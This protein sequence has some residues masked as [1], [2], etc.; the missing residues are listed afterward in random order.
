[1][2]HPDRSLGR[3][4]FDLVGKPVPLE[5]ATVAWRRPLLVL[6][7]IAVFTLDLLQGLDS[8]TTEALRQQQFARRRAWINKPY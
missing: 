1:M 8:F 5:Q 4:A 2:P 3:Y 6:T 7:G